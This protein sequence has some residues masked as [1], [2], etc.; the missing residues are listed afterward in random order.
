MKKVGGKKSLDQLEIVS[1]PQN[2]NAGSARN[3]K[4]RPC[5]PGLKPKDSTMA[6]PGK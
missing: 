6:V 4:A 2:H 1:H 3:G 5:N